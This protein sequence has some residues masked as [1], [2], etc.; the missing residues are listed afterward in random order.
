MANVHRWGAD[1]WID[2][3]EEVR[4]ERVKVK[5]QKKEIRRGVVMAVGGFVGEEGDGRGLQRHAMTF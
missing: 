5:K 1:D 3:S 2:R 4:E